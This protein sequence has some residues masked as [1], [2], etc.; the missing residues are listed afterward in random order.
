MKSNSLSPSSLSQRG[1]KRFA[2]V[3]GGAILSAGTL[4]SVAQLSLTP[5]WAETPPAPHAE[6]RGPH[7]GPGMGWLGPWSGRG[8]ERLLDTV[9]ATDAQKQQIREIVRV[10]AADLKTQ[11]EAGRDLREQ[12]KK[13]FTAP[14][15]DAQAAEALRQK[16]L[17]QHDQTSKRSLQA[18]L[19]ISKVLTPE[20]RAQLAKKMEERQ[21]K[22]AEHMRERGRHP[23]G[24]ASAP[25]GPQS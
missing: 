15:V 20:Q 16:M 11:R 14:Q 18:M 19:D 22:R 13:L 7:G 8:L 5:A 10:A 24:G 2:L 12:A 23:H 25:A 6:H 17:A 4:W 9:K 1:I 3:L 21:Q